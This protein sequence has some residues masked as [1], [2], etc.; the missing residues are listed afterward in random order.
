MKN[1]CT[2]VL[3]LAALCLSISPAYGEMAMGSILTPKTLTMH[4]L[5]PEEGN[6]D[7]SGR[8]LSVI[9]VQREALFTIEQPWI[10]NVAAPDGVGGGLPNH[11][12]VPLG[13][14]DLVLRD[15]P[16]RGLQWHLVNTDLHVFLEKQDRQYSWQ[17]YSCML[18]TANYV[19]DVGGCIGP[20]LRLADIDGDGGVDVASSAAALLKIKQYLDGERVAK[21]RIT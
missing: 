9:V 6:Y 21:L 3:M 11:S 4:T 13:E 10:P 7:P 5:S 14:Y 20:G 12:A 8:R 17:R 1:I 16:T 15:S 19:K 2:L 18:H